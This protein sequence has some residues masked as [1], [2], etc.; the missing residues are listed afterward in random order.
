MERAFKGGYDPALELSL[1]HA[2]D[3]DH[4]KRQE[5]PL[6]DSIVR[7]EQAGGYYLIVGPKG[8]GKGTMILECVLQILARHS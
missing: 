2:S 1:V 7:G 5:Q 8:C 4:I 3:A 6:I